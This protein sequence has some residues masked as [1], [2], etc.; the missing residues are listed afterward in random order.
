MI[1]CVNEFWHFF[2][3]FFPCSLETDFSWLFLQKL[4]T[5]VINSNCN[6]VWNE[7]LTLS[8]KDVNDPIRLVSSH[9]C[10]FMFTS[11]YTRILI[12]LQAVYLG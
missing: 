3:F 9:V 1:G 7:Q 8:I 10:V 12:C 6:P 11:I 2:F 4:K 5:R